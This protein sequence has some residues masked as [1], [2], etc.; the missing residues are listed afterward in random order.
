VQPA[1]LCISTDEPA[2]RLAL[3]LGLVAAVSLARAL[4]KLEARLRGKT[5][6]SLRRSLAWAAAEA[7]VFVGPVLLTIVLYALAPPGP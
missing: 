7:A 2:F 1:S 5:F 3:A 6:V 4:V